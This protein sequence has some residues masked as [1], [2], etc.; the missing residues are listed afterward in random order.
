MRARS[1][2]SRWL[3]RGTLKGVDGEIRLDDATLR[4]L[5]DRGTTAPSSIVVV[6]LRQTLPEI[7]EV[8]DRVRVL[9]ARCALLQFPE[10][11][12]MGYGWLER[13]VKAP[14]YRAI[15]AW[16]KMSHHPL[17]VFNV[18]ELPVVEVAALTTDPVELIGIL[19]SVLAHRLRHAE[20][21]VDGADYGRSVCLSAGKRLA[22]RLAPCTPRRSNPRL[23][24]IVHQG[25]ALDNARFRT[26]AEALEEVGLG[27][28]TAGDLSLGPLARAIS[29]SRASSA[30]WRRRCRPQRGRWEPEP[31][32]A[33]RRA[34]R[35]RASRRQSRPLW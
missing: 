17:A 7:D 34:C 28:F 3:L 16:V 24:V 23:E 5:S 15:E 1:T 8:L 4:A 11:Q 33:R 29:D 30:R 6:I 31:R 9:G 22:S 26:G 32:C 27:R 21:G 25:E 12:E 2:G 14:L 20:I 18:R 35:R 10:P 19:E 13:E